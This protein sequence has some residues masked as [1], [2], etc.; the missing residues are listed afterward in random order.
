MTKEEIIEFMKKKRKHFILFLIAVFLPIVLA[1]AMGIIFFYNT[2][3]LFIAVVVFSI[4]LFLLSTNYQT[5]KAPFVIKQT[6][7]I[8]KKCHIEKFERN[9][10]KTSS[11]SLVRKPYSNYFE[12]TYALSLF[13]ETNGKTVM[14]K[15]KNLSFAIC[16]YYKV[17]DKVLLISG[18]K[19]PLSVNTSDKRILNPISCEFI[20]KS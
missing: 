19:L 18:C 10:M 12:D 6:E 2:V 20:N 11:Y 3:V 8:I 13:I 5:F 14:K 15:A 17:G 4:S 9:T 1:I 16:D 7:G